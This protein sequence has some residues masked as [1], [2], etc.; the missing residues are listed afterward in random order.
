MSRS[1][2]RGQIL[3]PDQ[4]NVP[5]PIATSCWVS[6]WYQ[7]DEHRRF[8]LTV[9]VGSATGAVGD[10]GGFTGLLVL[11]GTNEFANAAAA[12]GTPWAGAGSQPG[13]NG[14]TGALYYQALPSGTFQISNA[15]SGPSA[16]LLVTLD[17]LGV[18][19]IRAK[20]NTTASGTPYPGATACGSGT[21]QMSFTAKNC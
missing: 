15:I 21:M 19:F 2:V 5:Q 17:Y 11:E 7:I 9:G 6:R 3:L 10:A 18:A 20:F 16:A 4:R 13:S 8:S 12:T 1:T 14:Y